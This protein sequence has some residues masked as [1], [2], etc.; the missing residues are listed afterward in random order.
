MIAGP[1]GVAAIPGPWY[2][3]IPSGSPHADL[4]K[5]YVKYAYDHNALGIDAPLG[6]AARTSAYEE[7]QDKSGYEAFKPL[8]TTLNAPATHGRPMDVHWQQITD[9]VLTPSVQKALSCKVAPKD[10]LA[11][12]KTKIASILKQ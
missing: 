4:A 12:A 2:N 9:E 8:L 11:E 1:G 5:Q 10:V 6:L 7:F 3:V